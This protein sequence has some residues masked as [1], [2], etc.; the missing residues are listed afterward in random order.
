M[1]DTGERGSS[2]E[3]D[4][5]V[6]GPG[7]G[8]TGTE[9]DSD[10][11][12]D[13][14]LG[15]DI[16]LSHSSLVLTDAVRSCP[17]VTVSLEQETSDA[18]SRLLV[19]S[20]AGDG[21]DAFETE[22]E[23]D[24]TVADPVVLDWTAERRIYRVKV[25]DRALRV[26]PLIVRSGG[27]VL[28]MET[29]GD[30]WMVRAQF[31]SQKALSDFRTQCTEQNITFRLD[32]LYWIS[33]EANAGACGLTAEQQAALEAAHSEG[34]FEVPRGISQAD[35]AKKLDISPSA[36]SQRIRRGMDQIIGSELGLFEE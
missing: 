31:R 18:E 17:G 23:V 35:L 10:A 3:V 4:Q 26:A 14:S 2:T 13:R 28:D 27:R 16:C 34:Y 19:I 5:P 22:L 8:P 7:Y 20:A 21:L 9:T 1:R 32:R 12:R 30:Q 24:Q 33:G 25:T 36:V 11:R 15:V 29:T 6:D